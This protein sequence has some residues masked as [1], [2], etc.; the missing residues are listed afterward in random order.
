MRALICKISNTFAFPFLYIIHQKV[1]HAF[2]VL[3]ALKPMLPG[4]CVWKE[5]EVVAIQKDDGGPE[6]ANENRPVP[7]L[8]ALFKICE[9]TSLKASHATSESAI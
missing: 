4:G 8:P 3:T 6:I 9:R 1:A 5:S 7:L 2:R